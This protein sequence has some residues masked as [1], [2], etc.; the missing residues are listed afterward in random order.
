MYHQYQLADIISFPSIFEGFGM[1]IIEGQ[2]TGRPVLS[3]NIAPMTEVAGD[4]ACLINP[5]NINQIRHGFLPLINDKDYRD[6]LIQKGFENV[7]RFSIEHISEQYMN[8]Y[9]NL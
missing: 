9:H 4:G 1:P 2:A 3:S 7:K 5:H 8:L 6:G